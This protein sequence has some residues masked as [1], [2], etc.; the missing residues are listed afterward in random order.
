MAEI[1]NNEENNEWLLLLSK[2]WRKF[3][4]KHAE[5]KSLK[6]FEWKEV[7]QVAYFAE[8]YENHF[9]CR[10]AWSMTGAPSRCT[11][12]LLMRKVYGMLGTTSSGL[13]KSYIDWMFDS[14][15]IPKKIRIRTIG[16]LLTPGLGNDFQSWRK[17]KKIVNRETTLPK[18]YQDIAERLDVSVN[19]YGELAFIKNALDQ[20]PISEERL[21]YKKLI[22]QLYILG[23]E[24][25]ILSHLR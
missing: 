8:R 11:E 3:F 2:P 9:G 5:I 6:P 13:I 4:A 10:Y 19:T 14:V 22:D 18:M 21:P 17:I 15:I 1:E 20:G 25:E 12:I 24:P 16:Y 23:L 7:H